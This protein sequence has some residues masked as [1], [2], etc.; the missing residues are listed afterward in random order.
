MS[1]AICASRV[2]R[3]SIS[4]I[5]GHIC[6]WA[7]SSLVNSRRAPV[8]RLRYRHPDLK[9]LSMAVSVLKLRSDGGTRT[10]VLMLLYMFSSS[11]Y[12]SGLALTGLKRAKYPL[13]FC[14]CMS[15]FLL[16]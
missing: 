9:V 3:L 10:P 2:A 7:S 5:S 15:V 13:S 11:W 6:G 14:R 8:R 1:V 12:S 4:R 16:M